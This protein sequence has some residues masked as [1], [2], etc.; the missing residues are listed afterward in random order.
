[1]SDLLPVQDLLGLGKTAEVAARFAER[2]FGPAMDEL[3]QLL[4]DPIRG[5]REKRKARF[6][7]LFKQAAEKVNAAGASA[8]E[9]PHGILGPLIDKAT[10]EEDPDLAERW[11]ALLA[12]AAMTPDKVLPS[13]VSILGELSP[14]EAKL[15]E[16]IYR[17]SRAWAAHLVEHPPNSPMNKEETSR[18]SAELMAPLQQRGLLDAL[19]NVS[20]EDVF[21]YQANLERLNLIQRGSYAGTAWETEYVDWPITTTA[22]GNVFVAAVASGNPRT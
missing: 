14:N 2:V 10:F 22:F 1:M 16:H 4:A 21:V 5:L 18:V 13:F 8:H 7:Q 3:G 19:P 12:N 11:A 9:V 15:L 17:H 6:R 20:E